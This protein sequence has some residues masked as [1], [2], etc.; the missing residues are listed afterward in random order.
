[1]RNEEVRGILHRAISALKHAKVDSDKG[2]ITPE[3]H[4]RATLVAD[5]A[6]TALTMLNL[7]LPLPALECLRLLE[8]ETNHY[9]DR[10]MTTV[11]AVS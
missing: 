7:G 5:S 1:M 10:Y 11:T 4:L 8:R 9:V 6:R 2:R 3:Q